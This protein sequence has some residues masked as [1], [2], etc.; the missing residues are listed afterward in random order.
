MRQQK[1]CPDKQQY[2]NVKP[3]PAYVLT[4]EEV[5]NY[6]ECFKYGAWTWNKYLM[7][8]HQN[9]SFSLFIINLALK[10]G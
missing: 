8:L 5:E 1:F 3:F 6:Y 7:F 2:N 4:V 9:V 10:T